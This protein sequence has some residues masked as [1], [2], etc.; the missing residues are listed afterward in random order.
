MP[1]IDQMID[2][3]IGLEGGYSNNPADLGGETMWGITVRVARENGYSGPMASLPRDLAVGI[4]RHEYAEKPGFTQVAAVYPNVAAELFDS[5]VNLGAHWPS[6]WLQ[7]ALN[8]FNRQGKLYADIQE[9]GQVGPA[10]LKALQGY[11]N[12]RGTEGELV[13]LKA[14]NCQQGQRYLDLARQRSANEEF[15]Y[16]WFRRI[17]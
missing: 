17:N 4:Y 2:R 6:L 13:L 12:I 15:A 14:L 3:T 10:T 11:K 7:I 16:G 1:T 9:D 5:G 8:A